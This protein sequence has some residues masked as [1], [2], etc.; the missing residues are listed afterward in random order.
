M[1]QEFKLELDKNKQPQTNTEF[2]NELMEFSFHGALT[3][4]FVIE[5]LRYYSD[6][7]TKQPKPEDHGN[8]FISA[9]AWHETAIEVQERLTKQYERK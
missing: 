4:V 9:I 1:K 7:I 6:I 2:L 5:A 3:Q 8:G